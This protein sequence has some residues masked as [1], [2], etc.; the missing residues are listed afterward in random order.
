MD[1][2]V[3]AALPCDAHAL[4]EA[5]VRHGAAGD[6]RVRAALGHM[7][8]ALTDTAE[9]PGWLCV[10]DP[11]VPFRGPGRKADVCPQ[12][13]AEALRVFARVSAAE[14]PAG[15]SRPRA[16]CSACG[17]SA[18]RGVLT[19]SGTARS[20]RPASGRPPGTAR[21]RCST[22]SAGTLSCGPARRLPATAGQSPSF[23]PASSPTQSRR[24]ARCA[25][26]V[27]RGLR[28][29][30][31]RP[32]EAAVALRHSPGAGRPRAVRGSRRRHSR[33]R[34]GALGSA[35]GGTGAPVPPK[36]GGDGDRVRPLAAV[37]IGRSRPAGR[38]SGAAQ[39]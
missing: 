28:A 17:A 36:T 23:A 19:C 38:L 35:K 27:L 30:L 9:G 34:L 20:S 22:R 1:A 12:V 29:A 7:E 14:R 4:A 6:L 26:L 33:R 31:L 32:E 10:P 15:C 39:A 21:S 3:W 8:A 37:K 18:A 5:L 24:T 25:A 2:P 16:R 11:A 13:T